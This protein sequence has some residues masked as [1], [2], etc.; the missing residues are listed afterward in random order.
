MSRLAYLAVLGAVL[1]VTLPLEVV[2]RTRVLRRPRRLMLSVLPVIVVFGAWDLYAIAAGHWSFDERQTLG[3]LLPGGLPVEEVLFFV[4]V[5]LASILA[6]EAVR[7]AR[8]WPV[9]DEP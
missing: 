8:G 5:P 3:V 2:L 4:V 1:L 7:R 9:G 6:L